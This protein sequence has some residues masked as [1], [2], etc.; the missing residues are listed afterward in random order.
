MPAPWSTGGGL[1]AMHGTGDCNW[2][3]KSAAAGSA[4]G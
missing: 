1:V 4:A 3:Q 2:R